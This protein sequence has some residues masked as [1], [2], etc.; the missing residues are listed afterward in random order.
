VALS[1]TWREDSHIFGAT[2]AKHRFTKRAEEIEAAL[3]TLRVPF[4]P[5]TPLTTTGRPMI[6]KRQYV[7]IGGD[8]KPAIFPVSQR[9]LN[10]Q[11]RDA[12]KKD[13]W[14]T[15]PIAVGK[16]GGFSEKLGLKGDFVKGG[17]FV[18]VEFGNV[19][20]LS[21]DLLKFQIANRA[22][23]GELGVLITATRRFA[24]FMD[25]G[26]ATFE[27]AQ[28]L[29]PAMRLGIQMPIWIIGIEPSDWAPLEAKYVEMLDTCATGGIDC[30]P[31][32]SIDSASLEPE[33]GSPEEPIDPEEA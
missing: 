3:K 29:L 22:E 30:H 10:A 15:E 28:A 25:Q 23:Q 24:K 8:R 1:I 31:Y 32:A 5:A 17:V 9:E 12:L 11:L 7:S 18:E 13:S 6:P 26:V 2:I 21:R 14:K 16:T 19:A 20:S 33:V 27:A 4:G